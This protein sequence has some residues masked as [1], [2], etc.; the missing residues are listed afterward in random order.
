LLA[1]KCSSTPI[2]ALKQFHPRRDDGCP[3]NQVASHPFDQVQF[4]ISQIGFQRVI[5][6]FAVTGC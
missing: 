6:V 3:G 1:K 5:E 2:Q 4:Q